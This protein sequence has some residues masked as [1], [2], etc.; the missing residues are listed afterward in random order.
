MS[1]L[2]IFS[3]LPNPRIWKATIAARLAGVEV[4][5]RGSSPKE[6]R[7]WLWDFDA[8]PLSPDAKA[9]SGSKER[10]TRPRPSSKRI[11]SATVPAAFSPDGTVGIFE[12]NSI[13][14]AV[15]RLGES[16]VPLYGSDPYEASRIDSFLDASLVFARD[17]QI[18]LLALGGEALSAEIHSR[19]RDAFGVYLSGINQALSPDREFI[20][21]DRLTLADICFV[22]ELGLFYN[23]KPRASDLEKRGL[24][25]VLNSNVDTQ[26]SHA[27]AHFAKLS[28]HPAF[29]PDVVPYLEKI[30]KA[31]L[32]AI[33]AAAVEVS[34]STA[35][36]DRRA[37]A[38][39]HR[40]ART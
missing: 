34:G 27:M 38:R 26:F 35:S 18:Y 9:A 36:S 23:E 5:I 30:E 19:T 3:Y 11:P 21:G 7:S 32:A 8:H 14:R 37:F 16:K 33:K 2:R 24:E 39:C 4:E 6:L 20:V 29:A 40:N 13:M 28:K 17:A 15:A 25:P 10:C 31:A 12:S 1:Q 22:A